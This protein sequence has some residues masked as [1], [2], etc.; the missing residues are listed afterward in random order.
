[1]PT[2]T[3]LEYILAVHRTKHF[4]RAAKECHVS[5]P[6]MSAQIQKVEDELDLV[7]F[8]RSKKPILTT[9]VGQKFI[10]Q[11]KIIL[12]EHKKILDIKKNEKDI[13]GHFHL[14]VIPTLAAYTIP[15]FI[16]S[17]SKKYPQ[18]NLKISE[19]K[20]EDIISALY[21]DSID[22]G[23]LVTPL[24][25][26]KIIERSLFFEPF[27]LFV[28]DQHPLYKKKAIKDSELDTE[29]IWLL[30]EGH[31]FR[32]QV[33]KVCSQRKN[34]KI[35]DNITFSSG[36]LETLINLVR[37]SQGY[38]LLPDLA[39]QHLS[40]K[41][42]KNNLKS[43]KNPIPTREVSIVH[44]RSFLKE[45][46]ISALEAEIILQLPQHLKSFKKNKISVIDI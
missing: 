45:N 23:L 18:V 19:Y 24:Q 27:Y 33:L 36:N 14:A 11:A 43:F 7:I 42:R 40:P 16:Q 13:S 21:D 9:S 12:K 39:T 34:K 44:S 3:Q 4:G 8:D 29:T 17:F 10:D 37:N 41:E 46:I 6:S 1:M 5:Q 28:S 38:T 15:L 26:N 32:D 22:A 25:D 2:I 35:L 30:E 20:T 31:C